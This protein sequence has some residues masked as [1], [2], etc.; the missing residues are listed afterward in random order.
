MLNDSQKLQHV[1]SELERVAFP[2][3][4]SNPK[5]YWD[6]V[7]CDCDNVTD[8]ICDNDQFIKNL[9]QYIKS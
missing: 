5:G 2:D 1:L 3:E 4:V 9:I 8:V 6:A 7:E